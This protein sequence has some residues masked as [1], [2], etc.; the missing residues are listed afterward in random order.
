M[1]WNYT[2]H[3]SGYNF[4]ILQADVGDQIQRSLVRFLPRSKIFS[5]PHVVSHFLARANAHCEIHG[6]TLAH[7]LLTELIL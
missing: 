7:T 1:F 5:L 6:F 4:Q 2:I 3:V